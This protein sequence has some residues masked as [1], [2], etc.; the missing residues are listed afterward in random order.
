MIGVRILTAARPMKASSHPND[1]V[2]KI[3]VYKRPATNILAKAVRNEE[4]QTSSACRLGLSTAGAAMA[5]V[6]AQP[7]VY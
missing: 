1:L 3:R 4:I 2:V 5:A 6:L 7:G